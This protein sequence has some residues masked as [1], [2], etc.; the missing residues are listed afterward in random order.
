MIQKSQ[1]TQAV[2]YCRVSSTKQTTQGNG[3]ASQETRCRE[4]AALK[5]Y[6][7][8]QTFRDD[9][10]GGTSERKGMV[11]ML[12]YLHHVK[13]GTHVVIIDDISRLARGVQ[14]HF[15]LRQAISGTGAAL[16]SPS[17]EFGDDSDSIL[18]ESMLASVAQHQRMKNAEQT[19]NRMRARL[20]NGYWVFPSPIGY[21]YQNVKGQGRVLHRDDPMA[22]FIAEG[23]EG[24]AAGRFQTQ[25]EVRRFF[26]THPEF[27]RTRHGE[28]PNQRIN[29]ILTRALYAGYVAYEPW[30][31]ALRKGQHEPLISLETYQ[32]IQDR[33]YKPA[34]VPTKVS[35]SLAF[36][37][38]GF[39]ACGHCG[40][41][42][43]ANWSK[44]RSGHHPYYIC[45]N[46]DCHFKGKSI[47]RAEIEGEF[48]SLLARL[49][50]SAEVFTAFKALFKD[51]WDRRVAD[52]KSYAKRL[53]KE[54]H[55]LNQKTT[56]LVDRLMNATSDSLINAYE[57]QI[58]KL[59]KEKLLLLE[60]IAQLSKPQQSRPKVFRTALKFLENPIN[61][62]NS[63]TLEDKRAVLKLAFADKP[64]YIRG[65]GFRTAPIA[66]P[67]LLTQAL[68]GDGVEMAPCRGIGD[69]LI[70]L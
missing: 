54:L 49:Q 36:P 10:S 61:L 69:C 67:F 56:G 31:I 68:A 58:E 51:L 28:I 26:E 35:T 5:G 70:K 52:N 66:Q 7:I 13:A 41:N 32:T 4:Y 60:K 33:L 8:A 37:L 19:K 27:P 12:S 17:I 1:A 29:E 48:E 63:N 43:T 55:Q 25:A 64:A 23:L 14:V 16:E 57:G 53:E 3:L 30:G 38:R 65:K 47:R 45:R 62:W 39:V 9:A 6:E 22:S 59:E 40:H 15:E 20:Q 21:T 18:V 50:P 34:K 24:F 11:A 2:I 44:G 42:L 46:R